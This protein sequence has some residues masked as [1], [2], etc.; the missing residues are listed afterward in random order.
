MN[1]AS[2]ENAF[3]II[4][5]RRRRAHL[6]LP[7]DWKNADMVVVHKAVHHLCD[8]FHIS[9]RCQTFEKGGGI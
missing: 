3:P 6:V 5:G 7:D 1:T 4:L 8:L 2:N 9:L